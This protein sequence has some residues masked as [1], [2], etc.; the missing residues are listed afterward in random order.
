MLQNQ[1]ISVIIPLYNAEKYLSQALESVLI[2]QPH[3]YEIIV[4]DD[5][6]TDGSVEVAEKFTDKVTLIRRDSNKGCGAARNLGIKH[7]TGDFLAFLDADDLWSN[8]KLITQLTF[9]LDNPDADIVFGQVEQFISPELSSDHKNKLRAELTKMPGFLAGGML[10]RNETFTR[11]GLF[12]E[13]LELGEFIDWYSR[14]KDIGLKIHVSDDV[15]LKR[16]IHT[17]NMG[18]Y[19][20]Q[21]LKDYTSV[22]RA[23]LERKRIKK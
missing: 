3:P 12:D 21:H 11:V 2:Q 9:L 10:I 20:K 23:A 5:C 18:V 15:V 6:S 16:R 4:V 7:A 1:K 8:N 14:A 17:N 19:K 13:K 22:L